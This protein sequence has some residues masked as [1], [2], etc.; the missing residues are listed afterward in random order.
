MR[1]M[2]VFICNIEEFDKRLLDVAPQCA[3]LLF[4]AER[5]IEEKDSNNS[6]ICMVR[7]STVVNYLRPR[8]LGANM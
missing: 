5:E 8:D 7:L 4:R 1:W 2:S 3:D 6:K